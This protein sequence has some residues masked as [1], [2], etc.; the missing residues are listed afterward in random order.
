MWVR[1]MVAD[2]SALFELLAGD[3][4]P[5]LT[6]DSGLEKGTVEFAVELFSCD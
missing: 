3:V 4:L 1:E 5:G 6:A 2:E